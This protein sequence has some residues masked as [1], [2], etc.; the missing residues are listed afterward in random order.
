M[1]LHIPFW[2][3]LVAIILY[4]IAIV[5]GAVI[6]NLLMTILNFFTPRAY[7]H[8]EYWAFFVG[9]LASAALA[10]TLINLIAPNPKFCMVMCILGSAYLMFTAIYNF[11]TGY[12]EFYHFASIFGGGVVSVIMAFQFWKEYQ[13]SKED[14]KSPH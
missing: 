1:K 13:Q 10:A 4:P 12:S 2:R 3:Y 11:A 7:Q 6:V 8:S 14:T 9:S 5:F